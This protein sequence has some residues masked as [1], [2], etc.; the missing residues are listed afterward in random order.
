[1]RSRP[2]ADR[3]CRAPTGCLRMAASMS[4]DRGWSMSRASRSSTR[5]RMMPSSP[6]SS[7]PPSE[8]KSTPRYT[9]IKWR[10]LSDATTTPSVWPPASVILRVSWMVRTPDT[11]PTS[12][13]LMNSP[14]FIGW[15]GV[16]CGRRCTRMCSRCMRWGCLL[17]D[18]S[19][20]RLLPWK[21]PSASTKD[22]WVRMCGAMPV[23]SAMRTSDSGV[24]VPWAALCWMRVA[25]WSTASRM[26]S[27]CSL[28]AVAVLVAWRISPLSV[29]SCCHCSMENK[30]PQA[31]RRTSTPTIPAAIGCRS[32]DARRWGAG[33]RGF[34]GEGP[35]WC[36]CSQPLAR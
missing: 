36:R 2:S 9:S 31:P 20:S 5:A 33:I 14:F 35:A 11:L 3:A 4:C 27:V 22:S 29:S 32:V 12:G 18:P 28:S 30:A 25:A 19:G 23:S 6:T 34:T 8:P 21:M 7:T 15:R 24:R 16:L 26:R 10:W 13:A 17:R 1:M